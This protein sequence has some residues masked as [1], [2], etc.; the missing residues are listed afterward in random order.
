[1]KV[2]SGVQSTMLPDS[3]SWHTRGRW[4]SLGSFILSVHIYTS[5]KLSRMNKDHRHSLS[6]PWVIPTLYPGGVRVS[7]PAWPGLMWIPNTIKRL[8]SHSPAY[9][10][11]FCLTA[12]IVSSHISDR[13]RSDTR[14]GQCRW[15]FIWQPGPIQIHTTA[16]ALMWFMP[17]I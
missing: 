13:R 8:S 16:G 4:Q 9:M 3:M 17:S 1:M 6:G 7:S 12:N 11:M 2:V 5:S 10:R 15:P 14:R